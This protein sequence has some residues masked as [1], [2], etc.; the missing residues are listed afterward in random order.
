VRSEIARPIETGWPPWGESHNSRPSK[1]SLDGASGSRSFWVGEALTGPPGHAHFDVGRR[2]PE[3]RIRTFSVADLP[4]RGCPPQR[5]IEGSAVFHPADLSS[6]C[7]HGGRGICLRLGV[8][9][10]EG[11]SDT[12]RPSRRDLLFSHPADCH[13]ERSEGSASPASS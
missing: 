4:S 5:T 13:H 1:G 8:I 3:A 2:E 9:L 6:Q 10:S 7:S 12:A 11:A